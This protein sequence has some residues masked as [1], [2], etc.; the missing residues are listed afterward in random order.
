[1]PGPE[2]ITVRRAEPDDYEALHKIFSGRREV[3][4]T[5]Q[6]PLPSLEEWRRRLS[7]SSEATY[8]L[9]ACVGGE[10]VGELTL[11]RSGIACV[12]VPI[13]TETWLR[14]RARLTEGEPE[15]KLALM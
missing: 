4:G 3:E 9:V 14:F 5:L 12:I 15:V 2:K 13:C 1:M 10:V 11:N 7:E 8:K 6:L